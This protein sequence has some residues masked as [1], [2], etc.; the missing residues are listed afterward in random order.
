LRGFR[1][2]SNS[3]CDNRGKTTEEHTSGDRGVDTER[4]PFVGVAQC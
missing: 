3:K 4:I 2:S 1:L